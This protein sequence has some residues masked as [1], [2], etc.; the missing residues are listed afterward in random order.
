MSTQA[1]STATTGHLTA[2]DLDTARRALD[3]SRQAVLSSVEG[4]GEV[5]GQFKPSPECWSIAQ[6]LEHVVTVQDRILGPMWQQLMSAPPPPAGYEAQAVDAVI[7]ANMMDRTRK[8]PAPQPLHPVGNVPLGDALE[9]FKANHAVLERRLENTPD[10][11]A[12]ALRPCR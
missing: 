3:R 7:D 10:L 4:I 6:I 11:R 1:V 8:F 9:R 5:Q 12:H 2:Q